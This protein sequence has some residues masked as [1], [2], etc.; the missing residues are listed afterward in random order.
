MRKTLCVFLFAGLLLAACGGSG[1]PVPVS[2]APGT[3]PTPV[4]TLPLTPPGLPANG[5]PLLDVPLAGTIVYSNGDG[6]I[7]VIEPKPGSAARTLISPPGQKGFLQEPAWSP[8]GSHLAYS[9]LLPFDTSGL[10]AQDIL[11][12]NADGSQ[13]Q[14]L[15][16]HT[17]NGEVY[18]SPAYSPDGRYLFFSHSAPIFN[19]KQITGVTLTLERYDFQAKQTSKVLDNG[20]QP[21]VSPDGKRIVFISINTNTFE[22]TLMTADLDGKNTEAV[23]PANSMGGGLN[24]PHWSRD[25]KRILFAAPNLTSSLPIPTGTPVA[26]AVPSWQERAMAWVKGMF[27]MGVA[28]AHGPPWDFW[29]VDTNGENLVR[30]TEIGEDEP[31]AVWSPDGKYFAF[32][33]VAGYYV[34][35]ASGKNVHWLHRDGGHGRSDWKK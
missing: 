1:T 29:L 31:G 8:D 19:G 34:V 27:T 30:L 25:S 26:Q 2:P 35:D 11:Q 18:A 14:T 16:A 13:P 32:V 3:A 5:F 17:V 4:P 22:Q 28:D 7:H 24:A 9:F 10:P 12:A 23:L 6:D 20:T 15:V 21:N 33:G